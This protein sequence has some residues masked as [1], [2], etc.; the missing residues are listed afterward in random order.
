MAV[1]ALSGNTGNWHVH[2]LVIINHAALSN[3]SAGCCRAQLVWTLEDWKML[4]VYWASI[5]T[6]NCCI[7]IKRIHCGFFF[8]LNHRVKLFF[9]LSLIK[10]YQTVTIPVALHQQHLRLKKVNLLFQL[11]LNFCASCV[12]HD[13]IIEIR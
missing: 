1:A 12:Q 11:V 8:S 9:S 13:V 4:M 6:L 5:D 10:T 3:V 7:T 2:K